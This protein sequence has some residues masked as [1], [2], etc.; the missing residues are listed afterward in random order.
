MPTSDD[1]NNDGWFRRNILRHLKLTNFTYVALGAFTLFSVGDSIRRWGTTPNYSY[2]E[3]MNSATRNQ[4]DDI[5]I[6]GRKITGWTRSGQKFVSTLP[7]IADGGAVLNNFVSHGVNVKNDWNL[8]GAIFDALEI[9][10]T[11]VILLALWPTYS[12]GKYIARSIGKA[13]GLATQIGSIDDDSDATVVGRLKRFKR[14]RFDPKVTFDDIVGIDSAKEEIM[15][16]VDMLK[17]P[18]KYRDIEKQPQSSKSLLPKGILLVGPP[19]CGKTLIARAMANEAGVAFFSINGS[20]FDSKWVGEGAARV[21]E[22]FQTA[23]RNKPAIIF[24]DEI[25]VLARARSNREDRWSIQTLTQFLKEIDGFESEEGI[26]LIGATNRPDTLDP[27]I[28]RP[29]R[30]SRHI[31][32]PLPD[33][34]GRKALAEFYLAKK[35]VS[36]DVDANAI[37]NETPGF[38]PAAIENLINEAAILAI[39]SKQKEIRAVD[40]SEAYDRSVRGLERKGLVQTAAQMRLTRWHEAGHAILKLC[41]PGATPLSRVSDI[42]RGNS[43]GVTIGHIEGDSAVYTRDEIVAEMVVAN[44]GREAEK[45]ATSNPDFVSSG[46]SSDIATV[47]RMGYSIVAELGMDPAIGNVRLNPL[48]NGDEIFT[49]GVSEETNRLVVSRVMQWANAANE[50]ARNALN[51]NIKPLTALADALEKQRTLSAKEIREIVDKAGG[52]KLTE[53]VPQAPQIQTLKAA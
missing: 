23:R 40:I 29:G 5:V 7:E 31:E 52:L 21:R 20:E 16:V 15:D 33:S 30:F 43:L 46:A 11:Q 27:A 1:D 8:F 37:A 13:K 2:T 14:K 4:I 9:G 32:V 17:N 39:R 48:P 50:C 22:V 26:T 51:D 44:G 25:D 38:S 6:D 42:P 41:I 28:L 47:T 24:I 34:A 36:E 19:G 49:G 10:R 35:R 53:R 18:Q 3:L 45:I 12:V